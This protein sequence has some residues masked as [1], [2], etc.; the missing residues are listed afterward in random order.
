MPD[1]DEVFLD[2]V[3]RCPAPSAA[4]A[5]SWKWSARSSVEDPP[6]AASS[7][8]FTCVLASPSVGR[9]GGRASHLFSVGAFLERLF[10]LSP[11]YGSRRER[12]SDVHSS[13]QN[14]SVDRP[15]GGVARARPRRR[16]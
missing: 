6:V 15:A 7:C 9:R 14:H 8:P 11:G 2:A 4:R 3:R 10:L 5:A 12:S 16:D 1:A 13:A